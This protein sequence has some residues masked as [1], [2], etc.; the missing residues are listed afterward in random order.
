MFKTKRESKCK[1]CC[2][3]HSGDLVCWKIRVDSYYGCE[4]KN[5]CKTSFFLGWQ[6][7]LAVLKQRE[8]VSAGY[9]VFSIAVIY[10]YHI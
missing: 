4:S 9:I 3:Q 6:E 8:K 5:W 7:R 2:I 10:I 1:L